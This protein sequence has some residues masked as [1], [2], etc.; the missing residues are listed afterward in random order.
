M[1][2]LYFDNIFNDFKEDISAVQICFQVVVG[3]MSGN[4]LHFRLPDLEALK[5]A[6]PEGITSNFIV[7]EP[8]P[9]F[10]LK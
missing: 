1:T 2:R 6:T 9:Y 8:Y 10:P 5:N 4:V 3:T 7:C